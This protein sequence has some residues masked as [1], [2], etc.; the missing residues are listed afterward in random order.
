[1]TAKERMN[2][3]KTSGPAGGELIMNSPKR[4]ARIAGV[5]YLLVAIFGGFSEGFVDLKMYVAGNAAGTAA[6]VLA[7][8]GLSA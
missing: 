6:N 8:P 5:F 2:T 1:M 3:N 4:L 7:D